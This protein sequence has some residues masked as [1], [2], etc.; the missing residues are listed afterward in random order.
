M[1]LRHTDVLDVRGLSD[2]QVKLLEAFIAFLKTKHPVRPMVPAETEDEA[3]AKALEEQW[4][5]FEERADRHFERL[6]KEV[7]E[8]SDSVELLRQLREERANR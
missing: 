4:T 6:K 5:R 7:G 8:T 2:E 1:Q 3:E